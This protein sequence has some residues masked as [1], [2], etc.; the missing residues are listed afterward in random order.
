MD[1]RKPRLL[2]RTV[3]PEKDGRTVK[4]LLKSEFHMA[5]GYIAALKLRP[6]GILLRGERVHTT[7]RAHAGDVLTVRVDDPEAE[8]SA[9]PIALPLSVAYEDE[10]LAVLDKP[11]GMIVHGPEGQGAP[12]LANA[13]AALWGPQPFHPVHRLDRGTSGLIVVAKSRYVSELLRRDLHTEAFVREYLAL[14]SGHPEPPT[15]QIELPIGPVEGERLRRC[16]RPDGQE[17][18]TDYATLSV[19]PGGSLLRLRLYTGRTHQIRVHLAAVGH[20]LYGDPL[21][22]GPK[23]LTRPALH[24]AFLHLRHPISGELLALSSPLPRDLQDF[25]DQKTPEP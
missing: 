13:L 1:S 20:P 5:E 16:V 6:D 7:A 22:G 12:T 8:N 23:G 19:F 4:S 21:Y 24:S 11:T 25:L 14:A 3:P 9:S 10:D 18:V 15:G 2:S 17:A